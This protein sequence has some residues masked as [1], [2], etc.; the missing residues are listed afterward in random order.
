MLRG[1]LYNFT[2]AAYPYALVNARPKN[3]QNIYTFRS[4]VGRWVTK[5]LVTLPLLLLFQKILR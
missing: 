5:L 4:L 3:A 1:Y 2:N